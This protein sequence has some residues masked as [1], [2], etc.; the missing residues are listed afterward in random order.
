[1]N[2]TA[3]NCGSYNLWKNAHGGL[4]LEIEIDGNW[5]LPESV[6]RE[7][8][9]KFIPKIAADSLLNKLEHQEAHV[10]YGEGEDAVMG[11]DVEILFPNSDKLNEGV[12]NESHIS[13]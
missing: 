2:Q 7:T 9:Y 12:L 8:L 11:W 10:L 1:M 4:Q 6:T 13:R 3:H 5:N